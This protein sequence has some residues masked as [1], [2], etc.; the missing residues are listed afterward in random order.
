MD[1][2][3]LERRVENLLYKDDVEEYESIS[4]DYDEKPEKEIGIY[5]EEDLGEDSLVAETV[6]SRVVDLDND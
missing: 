4:Y 2:E 1:Y 3:E 5:L 6:T